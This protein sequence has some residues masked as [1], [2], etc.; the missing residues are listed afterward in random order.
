MLNSIVWDLKKRNKEI[1]IVQ[2]MKSTK[3][4]KNQQ[5]ELKTIQEERQT[6]QAQLEPLQEKVEKM[7][8]K[9]ETDKGRLQ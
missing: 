9:L 8:K 1:S 2:R 6:R 5:V 3:E 4:M 7:I